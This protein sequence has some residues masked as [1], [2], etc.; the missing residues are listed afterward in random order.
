VRPDELI[1]EA[2]GAHERLLATVS[3]LSDRQVGRST[4]LAGWTVGHLITHLARNA[5]SHVRMFEGAASGTVREQYPE[6]GMRERDIEVG[7]GRRASVLL[8]DLTSS[9]ARLETAWSTLEGERWTLAGAM[10]T[11]PRLSMIELIARRSREV[12]LHHLDLDLGYSHERWPATFVARELQDQLRDLRDRTQ[13]ELLL[14]W[15]FDRAPAP[16]LRPW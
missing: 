11:G 15:L 5:D 9:C 7:A 6:P 8:E 16:T 1:H 4:R 3:R 2:S 12:E 10:A 13:P 14:A